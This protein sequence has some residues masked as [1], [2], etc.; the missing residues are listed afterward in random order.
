[1]F[2]KVGFWD[3]YLS[4]SNYFGLFDLLDKKNLKLFYY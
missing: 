2:E 3:V 1:M 4:D